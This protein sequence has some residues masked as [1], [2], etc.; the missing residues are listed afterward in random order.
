MRDS[1][2]LDTGGA[3]RF[4]GTLDDLSVA[5]LIQILQLAGK[6]AV[7]SI[8]CDG[9]DSRIWCHEGAIIAAQSG[10]LRGEAAVYR[11]LSFER[12]AIVADLQ[13]V[14]HERSIFA[15]TQR[16][17]LEGAR[18]KDESALLREKLGDL[19]RCVQLR[20]PAEEHEPDASAVE[21]ELLHS[22]RSPRSLQE[23]LEE[24]ELGDFE[25]LTALVAWLEAGQL[26]DTGERFTPAP[27]APRASQSDQASL[28]PLVA[29]AA[30]PRMR[31]GRETRLPTLPTWGYAALAA[32]VLAPA[33]YLIGSNTARSL[34]PAAAPAVPASAFTPAVPRVPAR[35]P[36]GV[37]VDPAEAELWLDGQQVGRGHYETVLERDGAVHELRVSADGHVPAR[38]LF[39]DAPPPPELR[40][41]PLPAY[42]TPRA[43]TA[44][45]AEQPQPA[46]PVVG[47]PVRG[48]KRPALRSPARR[49]PGRALAR[50]R[51]AGNTAAASD[52]PRVDIIE[53]EGPVI[54]V[55]D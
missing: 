55:L 24:S 37:R 44:P 18:R 12:G 6:G 20:Q 5:D 21:L 48:R 7:I 32:L 35:Y 52:A 29:S 30:P 34:A 28:V 27:P 33:G 26:R 53:G 16:L 22:F 54:R 36:V 46:S 8:T 3:A 42:V 25:T 11:I 50:A 41:E 38:I 14:A 23:A 31:V 19:Q 4:T 13:P 17:L 47:E 1:C 43:A 39:L 49:E 2:L 40:L 45:T 51:T 9:S 10:R 15:A